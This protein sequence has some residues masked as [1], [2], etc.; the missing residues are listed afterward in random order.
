MSPQSP[1]SLSVRPGFSQLDNISE[2][3]NK[4][5]NPRRLSYVE[6]TPVKIKEV[7]TKPRSFGWETGVMVQGNER[8]A[9]DTSEKFEDFDMSGAVEDDMAEFEHRT[10]LD[11][12]SEMNDGPVWERQRPINEDEDADAEEWLAEEG[13]SER[14][15]QSYATLSKRAEV[16]LENAKKRLMV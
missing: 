4:S 3:G 6:T 2:D 12:P 7:Y 5:Q 8:P 9:S 1:Q 11:S 10:A 14:D 13:G 15:S 16:I